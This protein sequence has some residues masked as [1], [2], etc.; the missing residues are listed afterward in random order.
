MDVGASEMEKIRINA[1][2]SS[3]GFWLAATLAF[4]LALSLSSCTQKFLSHEK[5]KELGK[6]A[7]F[8]Q[9]VQIIE[10]PAD[11]IGAL[12][13]GSYLMPPSTSSQVSPPPPAPAHPLNG[14]QLTG[15]QSSPQRTAESALDKKVP[16]PKKTQKPQSVKSAPGKSEIIESKKM[17]PRLPEIE[18]S[19]GFIGRRPVVDP[20]RVGE[21]VTHS[22]NY[23]AMKAG[24]LTLETRPFAMVNG[25]KN[26]QFRTSIK[27]ASFFDSFYSVD[28]YV[29]VLM[30]YNQLTPGVFALHVKES[31]QLK[32]AQMFFDFEKLRATY[33]EK[34]ITEKDGEENKKL[35]WEIAPY[36]QNVFSAAFYMRVFRWEV[37]KENAFSV[38]DNEKNLVFR[39]KAIRKEKLQTAIGEFDA[40]VIRPE[41]ELKGKYNPVGDNYIWLSDDDRKLILRIES[42]IKIGTL[43]SEVI[44]IQKGN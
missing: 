16:A 33:W 12:S 17:E 5:S 6:N 10:V 41:I 14:Q 15:S 8:E 24:T 28:D 11:E 31:A 29:D 20:F 19:E 44:D 35:E 23:F 1:K 32:E 9:V 34:K 13:G 21:K 26:Y 37:G 40:I 36:A 43:V 25:V 3:P 39:A 18:S 38:A 22:V 42:K 2:N 30:D 7:E 4:S 27:T